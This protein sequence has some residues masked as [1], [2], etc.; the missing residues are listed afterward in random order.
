MLYGRGGGRKLE[1]EVEKVRVESVKLTSG[2]QGVEI[3]NI[4]KQYGLWL[5]QCVEVRTEKKPRGSK[6]K[7]MDQPI[8]L[9]ERSSWT[10]QVSYTFLFQFI[11]KC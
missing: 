10:Y 7:E 4:E 11:S 8:R 6:V 5:R 3:T 9:L 2:G 1:M